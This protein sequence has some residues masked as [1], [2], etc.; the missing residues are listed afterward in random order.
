M[1]YAVH[2]CS[3]IRITVRT[4][5]YCTDYLLTNTVYTP[6]FF[7]PFVL[8]PFSALSQLVRLSPHSPS[9]PITFPTRPPL[10]HDAP[11]LPARPSAHPH[12]SSSREG[13]RRPRR[14]GPQTR[15]PQPHKMLHSPVRTPPPPRPNSRHSK[16][17]HTFRVCPPPLP[18]PPHNR[19]PPLPSPS[20]GLPS[21]RRAPPGQPAT[22]VR[23]TGAVPPQR[24]AEGRQVA[25]LFQRIAAPARAASH[26]EPVLQSRHAASA[27][28]GVSR[29]GQRRL[30][31]RSLPVLPAAPRALAPPPLRPL[32]LRA[33]HTRRKRVRYRLALVCTGE[34]VRFDARGVLAHQVAL[35]CLS[36]TRERDKSEISASCVC[37]CVR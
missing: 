17:P 20:S 2:A 6:H 13:E 30:H 31:R 25:H 27:Q 23:Q 12:H 21:D 14:L 18:P 28:L 19:R 35:Q 36:S 9:L 10:L 5:P 1:H 7:F 33:L 37:L 4:E 8:L 26:A 16:H 34:P 29:P 32:C 15:R 24:R 3:T 22:V 11:P